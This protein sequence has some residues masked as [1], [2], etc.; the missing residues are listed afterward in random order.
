M[1]GSAVIKDFAL[2]KAEVRFPFAVPCAGFST[3]WRVVLPQL[4]MECPAVITSKSKR[5]GLNEKAAQTLYAK[6]E[7]I[8]STTTP[9]CNRFDVYPI[10][11]KKLGS[12]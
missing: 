1:A 11:A 6:E 10:A 2:A 4:K 8:H 12:K 3:T 7:D 5:R 9:Y